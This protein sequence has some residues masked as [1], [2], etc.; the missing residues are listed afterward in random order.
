MSITAPAIM[1]KMYPSSLGLARISSVPIA[2][3]YSPSLSS[4]RSD[5]SRRKELRKVVEC[6][7]CDVD[8]WWFPPLLETPT[9]SVFISSDECHKLGVNGAVVRS[10]GWTADVVFFKTILV[11]M[12]AMTTYRLVLLLVVLCIARK[13]GNRFWFHMSIQLFLPIWSNSRFSG[14]RTEA[15]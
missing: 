6:R 1:L 4:L 12:I 15:S 7:W 10:R 13:F 3:S 2:K 14:A 8:R 11:G 5:H 9:W